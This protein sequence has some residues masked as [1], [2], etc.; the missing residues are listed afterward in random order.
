VGLVL[1]GSGIASWLLMGTRR[2]RRRQA[3][4]L[5][6]VVAAAQAGAAGHT[7]LLATDLVSTPTMTR[8]HRPDCELVAGKDAAPAAL[9]EHLA[10]DRQPC[11]VC[12]P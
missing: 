1:Q 8:Y 11:G 9:R 2:V 12:S 6:P 3:R 7:R 5:D 10:A 4:L